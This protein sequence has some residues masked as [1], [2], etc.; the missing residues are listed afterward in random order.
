MQRLLRRHYGTNTILREVSRPSEAGRS[1]QAYFEG[2]LDAVTRLP[3][4][5]QWHRF[6]TDG[7]GRIAAHPDRP[8]DQLRRLGTPGRPADSDARRGAREWRQSDCHRHSLPSG[9]RGKRLVDW[10]WRGPRSQAMAFG[11]RERLL[12]AGWRAVPPGRSPIAAVTEPCTKER[13]WAWFLR[14]FLPTLWDTGA[15]HDA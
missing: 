7:L 3:T 15:G 5:N 10:L 11:A 13:K 6:P 8:H 2:D 4:A 1:I 14:I 9:D 12:R